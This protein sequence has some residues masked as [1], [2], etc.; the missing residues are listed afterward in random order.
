[1][2]MNVPK[3]SAT[4]SRLVPFSTVDPRFREG[5]WHGRRGA[6][7]VVGT[8]KRSMSFFRVRQATPVDA[9]S[10]TRIYNEGI[11]DRV[12]TFETRERTPEDVKTWFDGRHPI[13]V[14][15]TGAGRVVA[16]AST[17]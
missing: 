17:S 12:G 9:E 3:N 11:V 15:E 13:V 14:V 6:A 1:M 16:F 8:M 7:V 2:R 4:A 10:I 5:L